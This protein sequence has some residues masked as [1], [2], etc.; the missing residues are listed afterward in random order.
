MLVCVW[1]GDDKTK[2]PPGDTVKAIG[3]GKSEAE[4]GKRKRQKM[5]GRKMHPGGVPGSAER[6]RYVVSCV[7]DRVVRAHWSSP[8]APFFC[9]LFFCLSEPRQR[10]GQPLLD[11]KAGRVT[12]QLA[13]F[14]D[15]GVGMADITG[16]ERFVDGLETA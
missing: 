7:C 14:L 4:S 1:N 16:A 5:G 13:R 9:R 11:G 10:F 3:K 2:A 15:A 12:E 6:L 8:R